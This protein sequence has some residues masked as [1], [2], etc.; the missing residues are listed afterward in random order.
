[1]FNCWFTAE[2][3]NYTGSW[4]A[5]PVSSAALGLRRKVRQRHIRIM[6][7]VITNSEKKGYIG[8]GLVEHQVQIGEAGAMFQGPCELITVY[9]I[10]PNKKLSSLASCYIMPT[11]SRVCKTVH[12]QC[13]LLLHTRGSATGL[14][15]PLGEGVSE[16]KLRALRNITMIQFGGL[17]CLVE[18]RK[19]FYAIFSI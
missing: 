8:R 7:H 13:Q 11:S 17:F 9:P 19:S 10:S 12:R 5:K 14:R 2:T 4:T 18:E 1:M 3:T 15:L 16:I 6:L